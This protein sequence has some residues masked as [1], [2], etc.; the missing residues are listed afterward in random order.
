[1]SKTAGFYQGRYVPNFPQKY[2]GDASKIFYRSSW[3]L[4]L[5]DWCDKNGGVVGWSSE[6]LVIPYFCPTDQRMHRYFLDAEIHIR[7]GNDV[8]KYWVELKPER[9]TQPPKLPKRTNKRFITE[10]LNYVKN[11]AKWAAAEEAANQCGAKF[12]V[13]TEQTLKSL[14]IKILGQ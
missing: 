14:G 1:M 2:R 9:Y 4:R 12:M 5:F 11:Q 13:W 10:T 7:R 3:E 6:E 8:I